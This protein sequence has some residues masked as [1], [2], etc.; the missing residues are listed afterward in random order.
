MRT[1]WRLRAVLKEAVKIAADHDVTIAWSCSTASGPP[2]YMCDHTRRGGGAVQ[3]VAS[4]RF[5]LLYD[6][7]HMQIMEGDIIRT[8]RENID[9]SAISIPR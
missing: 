7:Y 9:Y 5:K 3:R 2:G 8:I 1:V 4:P 6:I